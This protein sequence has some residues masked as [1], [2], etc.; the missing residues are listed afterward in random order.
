MGRL[1]WCRASVI[2]LFKGRTH[3]AVIVWRKGCHGHE[4]HRN[5]WDW[6]AAPVSAGADFG[7]FRAA[8]QVLRFYAAASIGFA[9]DTGACC[10]RFTP[11]WRSRLSASALS[12]SRATVFMPSPVATSLIALTR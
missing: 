5:V 1:P 10:K 8:A 12:P 11:V 2:S 4:R 9:Q 6:G 7:V 3:R